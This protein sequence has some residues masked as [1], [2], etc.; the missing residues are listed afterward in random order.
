MGIRS[1]KGDEVKRE[2]K[3]K[4]RQRKK[5]DEVKRETKEKGDEVKRETKEKGDRLHKG[6]I[7]V[8]IKQRSKEIKKRGT[9]VWRQYIR[10]NYLLVIRCV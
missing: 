4:E 9:I 10:G 1:K 5:G 3:K 8:I 7:R 6:E 2:M